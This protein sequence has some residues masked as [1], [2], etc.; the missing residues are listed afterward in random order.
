MTARL[1][2]DSLC[3]STVFTDRPHH[4]LI[5]ASFL[6]GVSLLVLS[7][8]DIAIPRIPQPRQKYTAIPLAER[9][10]QPSKEATESGSRKWWT[11][12][13]LISM[14]GWIRVE[15]YR[16]V[17]VKIECAPAGYAVSGLEKTKAAAHLTK[18]YVPL[19]RDTISRFNLRLLSQSTIPC[20]PRSF[21]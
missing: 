8:F 16:Q 10:D 11:K 21:G 6:S 15:L 13:A 12:V 3:S 14:L 5:F 17:T 7:R 9:V 18:Y 1:Q 20:N 2:P 4:T 19:V